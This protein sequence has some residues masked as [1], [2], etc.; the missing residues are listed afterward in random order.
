[1]ETK[2]ADQIMFATKNKKDYSKLVKLHVSG[3][4]TRSDL[5]EGLNLDSNSEDQRI[6]YEHFS[7]YRDTPWHHNIIHCWRCGAITINELL[8]YFK[9]YNRLKSTSGLHDKLQPEEWK[10]KN[11]DW[12][13]PDPIEIPTSENGNMWFSP[14]HTPSGWK[15]AKEK[16]QSFLSMLGLVSKLLSMECD[17]N[18]RAEAR[19]TLSNYIDAGNLDARFILK[20]KLRETI[21]LL[22]GALDNS[23]YQKAR[24]LISDLFDSETKLYIVS[25]ELQCPQKPQKLT[26][27]QKEAIISEALETEEGRMALAQCMVEPIR[28]TIEYRDVGRKLLMIDELPQGTLARYEKDV[29]AVAHIISRGDNFSF[30][31]GEPVR[32]SEIKGRIEVPEFKIKPDLSKKRDPACIIAKRFRLLDN[33]TLNK[34]QDL[35]KEQDKE[36]F[37]PLI[38]KDIVDG[39]KEITH[40][41]FAPKTTTK[42]DAKTLTVKIDG[43]YGIKPGNVESKRYYV[44]LDNIFD[45]KQSGD[46]NAS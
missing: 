24:K 9:E 7:G 1:M 2:L 27:K 12:N 13:K 8:Y 43:H 34:K 46:K 16:E 23:K 33:E 38:D 42:N 29:A 14:I 6:L 39:R 5:C 40:Y 18:N 28:N 19:T 22:S 25:Q 37:S 17:Y 3:D 35:I 11:P 36:I 21:R 26:N 15:V 44:G 41:S 31:E 4:I 10:E 45:A 20:T 32:M 30:K